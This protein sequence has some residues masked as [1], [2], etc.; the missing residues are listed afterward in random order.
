MVIKYLFHF[1]LIMF[2]IE[3]I[4]L[5]LPIESYEYL[6]LKS[7]NFYDQYIEIKLT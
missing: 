7:F 2:L 3:I 1:C 6:K 4:F 5:I